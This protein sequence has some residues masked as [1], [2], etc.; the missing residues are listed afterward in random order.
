MATS[1][2]IQTNTSFGYVRLAWSESSQ[3]VANNTTTISYTLSIY[4]SSSISSTAAKDYSIKINGITVASGT[5][6]IGGSGTKN[7]KTGT[8]TIT[9]NSDGK[10]TFS[11]SFSQEV[12]I[13][14]SGSYIG[15][16]TGSGSGTLD[17]I[18]RATTPTLSA[19]S[20]NMG[21]S[22]TINTPRASSSFTHTLTYKLGS[23][24]GTIAT[25]VE[26]SYAW[27]IPLSL[28]NGIPNATSGTCTVTCKT[29]NGNTLI[30]TK[31]VNFKANVPSSV[32]PSCSVVLSDSTGYN[33]KYGGYVQ[34]KSRLKVVI[35]ASGTYSS[36]IKSYKTT[37]EGV[38]Y[39]SS[40]FT[41]NVLSRSGTITVTTIVTDSRG[42]TESVSNNVTILAYEPPKVIKFTC[43]RTD[44][45][46]VLNDE[47][48][49]LKANINFEITSLNSKNGKSYQLNYRLKG[50]STYTTLESG[51]VY[52]MNESVVSSKPV[53]D[54]NS[55]YDVQ[56]V[57]GDDFKTLYGVNEI[58]S[59]F[60]I[61]DLNA[62]GKALAFGKVSELDEGIEFA[63]PTKFWHG[64]TPSSVKYLEVGQDLNNVLDEGFYAVPNANVS[65]S[66]VNKPWEGT[67]TGSLIVLRE[68]DGIGKCQ[69][70]HKLSKEDS[71]IYERS[72]YQ[73]SWGEWHTVFNGGGKILWTGGMYMTAGHKITLAEPI[74]KQPRGIELVF[75][76][77]ANGAV[78]DTNFNHFFISKAFV[79]TKAGFG[80]MFVIAATPTFE[81]I[82]GKYLYI[83]D[84]TITGHANNELAGTSNTT[85]I[86]YA[87]NQFVL[88][89]VIGV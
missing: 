10:K 85:G 57:V 63:L 71:S 76:R 31:T 26:T 40:N 27:K 65:G 13:T 75:S 62:N 20:A 14:W 59:A 15:T 30:G 79:A 74:S 7:I 60:S 38:P 28:A 51:T 88:R 6:T 81:M 55:S 50:A 29:Y 47:G 43:E 5:T 86:T 49:Y 33:A 69:I 58:S 41:S 70:A 48:Q 72:Y 89:Y 21:A 84:E 11:Y 4:R 67:A 18:P 64:E 34:S 83:N 17:T 22:I 35:T 24:S 78:A 3:N 8:T 19:T 56:L 39:T 44:S 68:G 53:L 45:T 73:N 23:A 42:R 1:G 37:I 32:I 77:Y 54:I 52:S 25:E 46:G 16:V 61:L 80:N 2:Q 66:L 9:H 82:A 12:A 87:N 36:T